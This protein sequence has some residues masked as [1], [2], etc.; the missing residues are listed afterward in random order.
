MFSKE[1]EIKE[2]NE[3]KLLAVIK[4]L[5]LSSTREEFIGRRIVIESDSSNVINWM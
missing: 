3:A 2:S 5:E 1:V 4:A